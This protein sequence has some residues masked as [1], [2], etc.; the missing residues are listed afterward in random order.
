[1]LRPYSKQESSNKV[2]QKY[3]FTKPGTL[4]RSCLFYAPDTLGLPSGYSGRCSI[5]SKIFSY[6]AT[7]LVFTYKHRSKKL[8]TVS[9]GNWV[10]FEAWFG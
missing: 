10:V 2:V 7:D 5:S 6:L 1:M 3:I 8:R 9:V 4:L